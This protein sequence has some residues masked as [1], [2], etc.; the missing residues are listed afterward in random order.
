MLPAHKRYHANSCWQSNI[1]EQENNTVGL[2]EH[3]KDAL[4]TFFTYE[5]LLKFHGL[6][7][8]EKRFKSTG[9][10]DCSVNRGMTLFVNIH[11]LGAFTKSPI[12][13][14]WKL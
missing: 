12:L 4:L 11:V 7:E 10:V 13:N 9:P 3:E 5:C 6:A 1:Y 8:H 2:S 14:H